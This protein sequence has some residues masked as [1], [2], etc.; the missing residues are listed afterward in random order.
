M[1]KRD[2]RDDSVERLVF[3]R[4]RLAAS[5]LKAKGGSPLP[6]ERDLTGIGFENDDLAATEGKL[7]G[8]GAGAP[9]DIEETQCRGW[10]HDFAQP[11]EIRPA[12]P[13]AQPLQQSDGEGR[14]L[15]SQPERGSPPSGFRLAT[16]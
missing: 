14:G 3:E 4:D 11:R 8:R 12:L 6:A 10:R 16:R 13:N 5:L 7:F 15:S 9:S 1:M 2:D